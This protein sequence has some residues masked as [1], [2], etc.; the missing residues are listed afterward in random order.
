MKRLT[1]SLPDELA[2]DVA[3]LAWATRDSQAQIVQ[4]ALRDYLQY[5]DT[6][7]ALAWARAQSTPGRT[8]HH[9]APDIP[10]N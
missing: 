5:A 2:E 4:Y 3:L 7:D 10:N 1:I 6:Q 9:Q 8:E